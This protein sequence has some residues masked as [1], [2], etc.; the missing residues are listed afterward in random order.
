MAVRKSIR[1]AARARRAPRPITQDP[2]TGRSNGGPAAEA[3]AAQPHPSSADEANSRFVF[4]LENHR[5]RLSLVYGAMRTVELALRKQCAEQDEEIADCLQEAAESILS[6]Q[7]QFALDLV[8]RFGGWP[9]S[10]ADGHSEEEG[11]K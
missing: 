5:L 10:S 2:Q 7:I 4:S 3:A 9:P 8:D 11:E 6:S 1:F